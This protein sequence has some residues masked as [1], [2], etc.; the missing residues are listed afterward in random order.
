[1]GEGWKFGRVCPRAWRRLDEHRCSI[2]AAKRAIFR[3]SDVFAS[4]CVEAGSVA[5]QPVDA[6]G[7]TA[8][9]GICDRF[10]T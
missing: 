5:G 3:L 7:A 6:S 10:V 8:G 9:N 4:S 2:R 1:M